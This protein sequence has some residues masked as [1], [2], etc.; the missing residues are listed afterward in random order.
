MLRI[1]CLIPRI[2]AQWIVGF[3][4]G[5]WLW[6]APCHAEDAPSVTF[7]RGIAISHVL[8]W[9]ALEPAPSRA[10][11]FPP[12]QI[13]ASFD[14]EL[15]AIRQTGFD[16]IRLAV[17]PGP[18]LQFQGSRRDQLDDVLLDRVR[19]ILSSGLS[20]IVDF[21]PSDLHEAYTAE[22]LTRG[23]NTPIFQAYLRLLVR[24]ATLLDRQQSPNVALEIMNEPPVTSG[25]WQPMLEAAYNGIRNSSPHLRLVLDGAD[26][27]S[28]AGIVSLGKFTND[29]ATLISF[30]YYDPYQFTH[31]GAAWVAARYLGDVPYPALA[32]PLQESLDASN[33]LIATSDLTPSEKSFAILD[34]RQRLDSYRRSSFDRVTI[35][36]NFDRISQWAQGHHV[37][38]SRIILGE[39][40]ARRQ[41]GA[42]GE[43]RS[44]ERARWIRDVREEA[45]AHGF[46]WAAWV[47]RG[48]G[49][50]SLVR[51]EESTELRSSF[52][53]VTRS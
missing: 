13:S 27:G 34:A 11:V 50:F 47:Y 17:D 48:A 3:A 16:F 51:D 26:E 9:A 36:K 20:V 5:A 44:L 14:T 38:L 1:N 7:H 32:R 28:A 10:F 8:A 52:D 18:F 31:Q 15:K 33:A 21:H 49:G 24:T 2:C 35:A 46:I 22:A 29:P 43:M 30:H 53:N 23:P 19:H 37:S 12:F 25:R 40:G 45:E 4:A 41:D 39:F 42:L 6:V